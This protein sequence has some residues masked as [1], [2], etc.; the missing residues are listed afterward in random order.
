VGRLCSEFGMS[1]VG[2]RIANAIP[3]FGGVLQL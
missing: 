3:G 2:G 1:F